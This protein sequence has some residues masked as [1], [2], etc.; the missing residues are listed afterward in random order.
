MSHSDFNHLLSS[1]K[2]LSPEQMRRLRQQIDS[3]LAQAKKPTAPP[4]RKGATHTKAAPEQARKPLTEAEFNQHLLSIGLITSLPDPALDIDDDDPDD[5]PVT[6]KGEP[7][8]ETI[9]R[10][11]R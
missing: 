3:E 6:I 9:I 10:E 2:A 11:R 1:L 5:A 8:S 4:A 7:L